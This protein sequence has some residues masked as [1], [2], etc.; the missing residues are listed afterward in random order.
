M[1]AFQFWIGAFE[2]AT[3]LREATSR[4]LFLIVNEARLPSGTGLN[5][6]L[7]AAFF[8]ASKS[9][10]PAAKSCFAFSE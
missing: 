10:P 8:K 1:F 7:K 2:R 3:T 5:S 9:W 6:R 4:K